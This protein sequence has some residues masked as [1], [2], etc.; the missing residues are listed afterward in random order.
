[1]ART[2]LLL[3]VDTGSRAPV[4]AEHGFRSWDALNGRREIFCPEDSLPED[5]FV[6]FLLELIPGLDLRAILEFYTS[7]GQK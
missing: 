5:D 1:M 2:A 7:R 3:V 4:V 6:Y